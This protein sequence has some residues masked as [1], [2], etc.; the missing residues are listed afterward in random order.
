VQSLSDVVRKIIEEKQRYA[1]KVATEDALQQN[2]FDIYLFSDQIGF[3]FDQV[4]LDSIF[5]SLV[6]IAFYG[7]NPSEIPI[8][9]L[10]FDTSLPSSDE[11]VRG[12]IINVQN[13]SCLDKYPEI[14]TYINEAV[15]ALKPSMIQKCYWGVSTY[16]DCYVDPSVVRDYLRSTMLRVFKIPRAE[17]TQKKIH[18]SFI[19]NL[20]MLPD[21]MK[22]GW[23]MSNYSFEAKIRDPYWDYAWWDLSFWAEEES[24]IV[25]YEKNPVPA[26]PE[27]AMDVMVVAFWDLGIWD[28]SFWAEETHST[29]EGIEMLEKFGDL[30]DSVMAIADKISFEAKSRLLTTPLIVANYQ[31]VEERKNWS[32]SKR[33]D[34]FGYSKVWIYTIRNIVRSI[35]GGVPPGVFRVYESAAMSLVSRVGRQG[36]WG[37]EAFRS[38]D[39]DTFRKQWID[40]WSNKGLDPDLLRNIFDAVIREVKTFSGERFKQKVLRQTLYGGLF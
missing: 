16:G 37:Y 20:D 24:Y 35:V 10:C 9:N 32:I 31:T 7:L 8:F 33:V 30:Y 2:V 27:H 5:T 1:Q 39:M 15:N 34:E 18:D 17:E 3:Q 13:I 29:P 36:G 38:M 25:N 23:E 21:P 14:S 22:A 26:N 28:Y 4:I 40:E 12:K 19:A 11:Y 6:G